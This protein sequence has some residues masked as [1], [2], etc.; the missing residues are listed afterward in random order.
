MKH[1]HTS[2]GRKRNIGTVWLLVGVVIAVGAWIY[3]AS[4]PGPL[5]GF[6]SC[7]KAKGAT[8]YGAFWCPHCQNQKALFGRSARLLPYVECSTPDGNGQLAAC[9]DKGVK[10]YP[11]WVFSDGSVQT[12]EVSL[13]DLADKS[14]CELPKDSIS[15]AAK[16]SQSS[17]SSTMSSPSSTTGQ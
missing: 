3:Y 17:P 4:L 13:K 2:V 7:L 9:T 5:D 8:F 15:S 16:S 6:A 1:A 10:N 12:G 11:T 14:G